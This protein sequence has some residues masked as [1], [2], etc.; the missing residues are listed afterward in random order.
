MDKTAILFPGQGSQYVGMGANLIKNNANARNVYEEASDVLGY[1]LEKLCLEG[2]A[3]ELTRT[4]VAQP[5]ILT[6]SIATYKY[7]SEQFE[8]VPDFLAGHS[9]GEFSALVAA[10]VISFQ[11]AVKI[12]QKRGMLMQQETA[13]GVGT[14]FAINGLNS[15]FIREVCVR[16]TSDETIVEIS[17]YNSIKQT[18]I[19][20]HKQAVTAAVDELKKRGGICIPLHV[21]APFHCQLMKPAADLFKK[22]LQKYTFGDFRYPV[23]SNVTASPYISKENIVDILCAQIYRPV[24][25]LACMQFL[26]RESVRTVIDVGPTGVLTKLMNEC[27]SSVR[28]IQVD[29]GDKI[30]YSIA[31]EHSDLNESDILSKCLAIAVTTPNRNWNTE[32]Y[33]KGVVEPTRNLKLLLDHPDTS[34]LVTMEERIT[35]GKRLL[36]QILVTKK[37]SLDEMK[38]Q[39]SQINLEV[40]RVAEENGG[41]LD[42]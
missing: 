10:G 12:V 7:L 29:N 16:N 23:L 4:E 17:N 5:A 39:L 42:E 25:W 40:E 36:N 15:D 19:S 8:F 18:V 30:N 34:N 6:T 11:D 14:M 20:G 37:I 26:W 38:G 35:E 13:E 3:N 22:E 24:N 31:H 27:V 32:E 1:D 28:S 33:Q 9:L 41:Q 21:S 2:S